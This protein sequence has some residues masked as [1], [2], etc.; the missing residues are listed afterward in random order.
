MQIPSEDPVSSGIAIAPQATSTRAP[1]RWRPDA[2]AI[3]SARRSHFA[4][5][6]AEE[7]ITYRTWKRATLT[8]YFALAC[9][10]AAIF[11]AIGGAHQSSTVKPDLR[12]EFAPSIQ[13]NSR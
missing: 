12:S 5:F 13:P 3:A 9:F 6:T 11:I 7:R 10:T 2:S 8:L 1:I 4:P